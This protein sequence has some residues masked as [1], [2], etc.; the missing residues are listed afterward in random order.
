MSW[1]GALVARVSPVRC[2]ASVSGAT[3]ESPSVD[4][5]AEVV[6]DKRGSSIGTEAVLEPGKREALSDISAF[7]RL[8]GENFSFTLEAGLEKPCM[9]GVY[10]SML[11]TFRSTG[12]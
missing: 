4:L 5:A 10:F 7:F 1:T 6:L 2:E 12:E 3:S 8:K 9:D 11:W